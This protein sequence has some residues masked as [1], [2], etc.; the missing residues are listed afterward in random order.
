[1]R[2]FY[3]MVAFHSKYRAVIHGHILHDSY[4]EK[5][6]WTTRNGQGKMGCE[7]IRRECML[8]RIRKFLHETP[9]RKQNINNTQ[10]EYS[11]F[12]KC[13]AVTGRWQPHRIEAKDFSWRH[14]KWWP[15]WSLLILI[16]IHDEDQCGPGRF[17]I[18]IPTIG[19]G[20][21]GGWS[22]SCKIIPSTHWQFYIVSNI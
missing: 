14:A 13:N 22:K 18:I 19:P 20:W 8:W 11:T 3:E 15:C 21:G 1:M 10:L 2:S 16:V 4:S 17:G 9:K 5:E 6:K 12:N 7:I